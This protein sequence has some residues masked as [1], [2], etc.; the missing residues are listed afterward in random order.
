MLAAATLLLVGSIVTVLEYPAPWPLGP[1][2]LA[3]VVLPPDLL[4]P[5]TA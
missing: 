2:A 4:F 1:C 3:A 5:T